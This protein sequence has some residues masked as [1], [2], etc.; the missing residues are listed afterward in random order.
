[1]GRH[2]PHRPF[3][4]TNGR[5][6]DTVVNSIRTMNV[7]WRRMQARPLTL[8]AGEELK[9]RF[10]KAHGHFLPR[11]PKDFTN[12]L[13]LIVN[14]GVNEFD[15]RSFAKFLEAILPLSTR[16]RAKPREVQ[17]AVASAVLLT[18]YIIQGCQRAQNHWALFEAWIVM[19]AHIAAV[20]GR[21]K[22]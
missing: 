14:S 15:K 9:K 22:T 2:D 19:A 8:V 11:E 3:L 10:V 21:N 16:T 6:A 1:V 13:E 12:F 18:T 17:R 5:V 4:A 20:S 7:R